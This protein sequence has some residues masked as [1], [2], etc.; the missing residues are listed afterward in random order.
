MF[1]LGLSTTQRKQYEARLVLDHEVNIRIEILDLNHIVIDD[2]SDRLIDGQV[3]INA[4]ADTSTRSLTLSLFDPF[5]TLGFDTGNPG[6][7]ILYADRMIRIYY[8]VLVPELDRTNKWVSVPVFTGPV[9]KLSR[10]EN[11]LSIDCSGKETLAGLVW[12]TYTI[13]AGTNKTSAI[14][15]IMAK[16]GENFYGDLGTSDSKM[17]STHVATQE[18]VMW[19]QAEDFAQSMSRFLYYDGR[20]YLN[21]KAF[22]TTSVFTM[23]NGEGGALV[24]EPQLSYDPDLLK[25]AVKITGKTP[26]K[27]KAPSGYATAPSSH[28]LSPY[29]L[30]RKVNGVLVPRYIPEIIQSDSYSS[31]AACIKA[32]KS[33]LNER[34]DESIEITFD[35][36]TIPHIEMNDQLTVVTNSMS[37]QFRLRNYSIPLNNTGVMQIGYTKNQVVNRPAIRNRI[38]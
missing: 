4:A 1:D 13:K 15:L 37:M 26:Q 11:I 6:D 31:N 34:L 19:S 12:Q 10:E 29:N 21:M 30:G 35:S 14:K 38:K 28:P 22:P 20:G 2:I 36:V 5:A 18:T 7:G 33:S 23:R 25:N 9:V 17:K 3:T 24:N 8:E 32:A 16:A 27:G